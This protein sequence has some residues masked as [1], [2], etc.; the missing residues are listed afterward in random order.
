MKPRVTTSKSE[1]NIE[2]VHQFLTTAYWAKGRT[3]E[4]VEKT[5]NYSLCFGI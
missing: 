3:K 5:I 4:E 2:F 1:L